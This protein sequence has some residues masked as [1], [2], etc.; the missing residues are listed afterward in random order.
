MKIFKSSVI[1][2][3]SCLLFLNCLGLRPCIRES[4][5]KDRRIKAEKS[6]DPWERER[7]NPIIVQEK[8]SIETQEEF[9]SMK[10]MDETGESDLTVKTFYQIQIFASKFPEEAQ[11]LADSLESN[12]EEAVNI[13]YDA[14]YYKVRMGDFEILKEAESFLKK[15]RQKGF[16]QAWMVKIKKEGREK[17]GRD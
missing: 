14:P 15:I 12:F 13:H 17:D 1:I 6:F 11:N 7:G 8:E 10:Q 4:R 5:K 3:L 9:S 2:S 16:P